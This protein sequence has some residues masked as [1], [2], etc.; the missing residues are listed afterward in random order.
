MNQIKISIVVVM[1]FASVVAGQQPFEYKVFMQKDTFLV[2]ELVDI[3]VNIIN[4]SKTIQKSG[5]VNIK[6][7]NSDGKEI[8]CSHRSGDSFSPI[9]STL[10]PNGE[11]YKILQLN[12]FF[13]ITHTAYS[14]NFFEKG[15]Y[16]IKVDF[17]VSLSHF[18]E[19]KRYSIEKIIK[20]VKP[21]GSEA[22]VY[23]SFV[24][25]EGRKPFNAAKQIKELE[26][27][28][29]A[30]PNSVYAP[31]IL[32]V[33]SSF[34]RILLHDDTHNEKIDKKLMEDYSWSSAARYFFETDFYKKEI[35]NK[36]KR[37]QFLKKLIS[38]AKNSPMQKLIELKLKAELEK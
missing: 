29:D 31:H 25:I 21:E 36:V 28:I 4:I 5:Y 37:T 10:K 2:G 18:Y 35:P 33:I 7:L 1:L 8:Q 9:H 15:T 3:G 16:K 17:S 14:H 11:S 32:S 34:Y 19:N 23:N 30:H 27:L 38:G 22:V 24:E 20:I 6:M 26:S 12:T 13:G